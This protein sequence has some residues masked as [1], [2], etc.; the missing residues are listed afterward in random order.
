[1][2]KCS[3]W[4]GDTA[5]K[6]KTEDWGAGWLAG[7]LALSVITVPILALSCKLRLVS[8]QAK[9]IFQDG[10][11][12]GKKVGILYM[13]F[14]SDVH[15][16]MGTSHIKICS[17]VQNRVGTLQIKMCSNVQNRMGTPHIKM[18]SDVQNKVGTP[19]I[20]MC[21]DVQNRVGTPHMIRVR[22]PPIVKRQVKLR[23]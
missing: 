12:C 19:H 20:K 22:I 14:C 7:L 11:E 10:S 1:M 2:F 3:Y 6:S 17:D 9:L 4:G 13:K 8:F 18:C 15:T 21:S 5:Q 16:M 23:C